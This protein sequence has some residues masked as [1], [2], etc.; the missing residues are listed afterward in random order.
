MNL[1]FDDTE[2]IKTEKQIAVDWFITD[3]RFEVGNAWIKIKCSKSKWL[4]I[5]KAFMDL[6][7]LEIEN[8]YYDAN[9]SLTREYDFE[10]TQKIEGDY[11]IISIPF[12]IGEEI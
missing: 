10:C 7:W 9:W 6:A 1:K 5:K 2:I 8:K 12:I 4:R 3:K 11:M